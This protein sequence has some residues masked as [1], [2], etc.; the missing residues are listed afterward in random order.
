LD[1]QN[2]RPL[3]IST[4]SRTVHRSHSKIYHNESHPGWK[5]FR[6][7]LRCGVVVCRRTAWE[8][9]DGRSSLPLHI[10]TP[11]Q[12]RYTAI[13]PRLHGT[14]RISLPKPIIDS[15]GDCGALQ[16]LCGKIHSPEL[17]DHY[18]S[19]PSVKGGTLQLELS[20]CLSVDP[21]AETSP[22]EGS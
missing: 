21:T 2:S 4:S 13:T 9:L 15:C 19:A 8:N 3:H 11:D 16:K 1:G 10:S 5:C 12:R 18:T 14:N 6:F 17:H 22:R 20:R 7:S